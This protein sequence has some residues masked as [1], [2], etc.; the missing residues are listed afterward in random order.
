MRNS[1]QIAIFAKNIAIMLEIGDTVI[2]FDL[3][4][5][6]FCC[7]LGICKGQCCVEGDAGAPLEIDEL[8]QLEEA[9]PIIWN[10]LSEAARRVIDMQGVAYTD[11]EGDL[12]TS[13][14]NQRECV[15]SF[16]DSADGTCK[17]AIEKAYR[18]G[19]SSFYK[20]VS[21]HLYPVRIKKFKDFTAVSY[22]HW[23]V[24]S[25][26]EKKGHIL[27]LP[28]YKFLKTPLIRRFGEIWYKELEEAAQA[29]EA[30][31]NK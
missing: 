24:C 12:V 7:D 4:E 9:L 5:Q 11:V 13:I 28:V 25:C 20:P 17:C 22:H 26:A 2:S 6:Q 30:E 16:I 19:K 15:F 14:V 8:A 3:F 10:D 29:Y 23:D 27:Q 1:L 21:C 18:E 31:F